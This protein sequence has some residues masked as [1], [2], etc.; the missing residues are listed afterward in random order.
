MSSMSGHQ[1]MIGVNPDMQ[2][3]EY[4]ADGRTR[5]GQESVMMFDPIEGST[6]N[7]NLWSSSSSGMTHAVASGV[8][9]LNSGSDK[10]AGDYDILTSVMQPILLT[11]FPIYVTIGARVIAQQNS[12]I[13]FGLGFAAGSSAPIDG[14]FY[15]FVNGILYGVINY[16][17]V[18]TVQQIAI[19]P[20]SD[21][22]YLF[23]VTI[24]EGEV[25]FAAEQPLAGADLFAISIPI[26]KTQ[27]TPTTNAHQPI[28]MRVY[29]AT[30]PATAAQLMIA[31][32][33]VTQEDLSRS[34]PWS[35]ALAGFGRGC[36]QGPSTASLTQTANHANSAA[37][38]AATLSNTAAGYTTL[39]GKFSFA[40]PAGAETDY[41]LFGFQVPAGFQFYCTGI[42]ISSASLGAAVGL[43]PSVLE[44]AAAVNCSTVSLATAENPPTSW[45]PR[46]VPLGLQSFPTLAALGSVASDIIRQFIPPLVT[47][48][49]RFFHIIVRVPVGLATAL[50]TIRGTVTVHGYFE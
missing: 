26:P 18:E 19:L 27:G 4:G 43:T 40:A 30:T 25:Q 9:T 22:F 21:Q 1:V 33:N 49:G 32:V 34:K 13:E 14:A 29:N 5:T 28:F 11:E 3:P 8:L 6:L 2:W 46:R 50:Q 48:S 10:V 47:D 37:P 38:S 16:G 44:W 7:T 31:S 45:A 20:Q 12:V 41:A 35:E 23:E 42:E 17:G 24:M 39:G 36:Y 15:R